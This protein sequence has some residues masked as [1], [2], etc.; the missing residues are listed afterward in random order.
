[1]AIFGQ[2]HQFQVAAFHADE[3][4]QLVDVQPGQPL[5]HRRGGLRIT[6]APLL[7][8]PQETL[9][10]IEQLAGAVLADHAGQFPAEQAHVAAEEAF[11]GGAGGNGRTGSSG[12]FHNSNYRVAS[13]PLV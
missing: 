2:V 1:M 9:G 11:I 6:L 13:T 4:L 8:Q 12:C 10:Q 7:G 3:L 5:F